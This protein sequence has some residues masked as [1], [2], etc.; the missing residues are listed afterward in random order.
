MAYRKPNA[1]TSKVFNPIALRFGIGG[2][3]RL[4]VRG[5]RSGLPR[6][7]PVVPVEH[8]G[9]RYLVSPRGETE[10]VRNLRAAGE[11][12]LDGVR[13]HLTEVPVVERRPIL[14]AYQKLAGRAVSSHFKALPDAADH[15]VF[16]VEV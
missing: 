10:W 16:R 3:R 11:A 4:T 14:D 7:I 5:R 12:E 6:T 1:F 9:R 15:P 2:T 8:D 13:V